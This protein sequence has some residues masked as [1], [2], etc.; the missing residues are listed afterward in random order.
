METKIDDLLELSTSSI[1]DII[2]ASTIVGQPIKIGDDVTII[3]LSK[4]SVGFVIGGGQINPKVKLHTLPLAG[5]STSGISLV[6]IGFISIVGSSVSYTNIADS[7]TTKE[8][9]DLSQKIMQKIMGDGNE[10][11]N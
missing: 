11:K 7:A 1:K 2:D 9:L 10:N 3:T 5:A 8:L 6:P 4:A